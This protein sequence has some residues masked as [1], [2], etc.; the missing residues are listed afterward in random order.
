MVA[1]HMLGLKV[2]EATELEFAGARVLGRDGPLEG[3]IPA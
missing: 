1:G 2:T 3:L